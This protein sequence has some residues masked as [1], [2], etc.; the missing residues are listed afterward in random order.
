MLFLKKCLVLIKNKEKIDENIDF[1]NEKGH[2]K[3]KTGVKKVE[4]INK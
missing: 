1:F 2:K 3:S 4:K